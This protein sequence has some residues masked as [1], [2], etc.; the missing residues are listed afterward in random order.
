M[1]SK[2]RRIGFDFSLLVT[3]KVQS[4]DR[5]LTEVANELDAVAYVWEGLDCQ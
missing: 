1:L 3:Q 5:Q 2:F 4:L